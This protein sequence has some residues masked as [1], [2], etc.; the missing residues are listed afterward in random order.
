MAD[1]RLR[2]VIERAAALG[3]IAADRLAPGVYLLR[4]AT[5]DEATAALSAAGLEA[6]P[7]M[8]TRFPREDAAGA[9]SGEIPPIAVAGPGAGSAPRLRIDALRDLIAVGGLSRAGGSGRAPDPEPRLT[10]LRASLAASGRAEEER[11]ELADRI[12]RRLVLT[13]RQI[14]QSDPKPERLEAGGLD[15]LGKVRVV[16]RALR[17]AGDRLEVLYRLPGEE[18]SGLSCVQSGSTRTKRG[19][20]WKPKTSEP[21]APHAYPSAP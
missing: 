5:P 15:Y 14:A 3:K 18:P 11:R 13:E 19:S 17:A 2:P 21:A 1:E 9:R 16:E 4:A 7:L 8:Q 12:E 20:S 10:S 6:P